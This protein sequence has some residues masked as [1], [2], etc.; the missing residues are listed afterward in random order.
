M[1]NRKPLANFVIVDVVINSDD[2]KTKKL[3][4]CFKDCIFKPKTVI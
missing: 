2:E 3:V 1:Q 4:L